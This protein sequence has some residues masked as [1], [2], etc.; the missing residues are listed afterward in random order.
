MAL[1]FLKKER[2]CVHVSVRVG[3]KE[4]GRENPKQAPC[5]MWSQM[6]GFFS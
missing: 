4:R 2:V 6:W 3:Q 1:C 5:P